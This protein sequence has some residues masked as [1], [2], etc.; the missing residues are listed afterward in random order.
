VG[1]EDQRGDPRGDNIAGMLWGEVELEPE[2]RDW[3][4]SL[5]DQRW[6]QAMFHL[7]LLTAFTKTRMRETAE[8]A[9]AEAAM[10]RCQH[11]G[12]TAEADE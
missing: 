9:R 5:D 6:A 11:E 4:D 7:D 2:V 12:H 8:I 3:L 1:C 10:A